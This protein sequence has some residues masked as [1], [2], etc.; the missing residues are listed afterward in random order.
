MKTQFKAKFLVAFL[1][2]VM[3]LA[4]VPVSALTAFAAG[5]TGTKDDPVICST[6]SDFKAAM[7]DPNIRFV[8]LKNCN[9]ILPKISGNELIAAISVAGIKHLSLTGNNVF[10]VSADSDGC[11]SYDSLLHLTVGSSM[12]IDGGGSLTFKANLNNGR[13]AVIYNQGGSIAIYSGTLKGSYNTAVYGMAIWQEY[14]ELE[15]IDGNFVS[16]SAI[17][18]NNPK[19]SVYLEG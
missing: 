13:N 8:E 12:S 10:T 3:V 11:K 1:V 5:G 16:D 6:Y 17:Q 9:E 4:L 14:G 15:I 19:Y 2:F 18:N 7:E